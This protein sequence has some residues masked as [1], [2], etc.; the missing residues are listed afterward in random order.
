M[1]G[2]RLAPEFYLTLKLDLYYFYVLYL[3]WNLEFDNKP[4]LILPQTNTLLTKRLRLGLKFGN[5]IGIIYSLDC[6]L[7]S[8]KVFFITTRNEVGAR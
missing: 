4:R 5:L 1:S 8:P 6:W 7:S 2:R 3:F